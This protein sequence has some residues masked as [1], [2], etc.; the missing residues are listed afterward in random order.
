MPA[1]V[2]RTGGF[3]VSRPRPI[4]IATDLP[5]LHY[6]RVKPRTVRVVSV[7]T[8]YAW[9]PQCRVS[10]MSR[11]LQL[12]PSHRPVRCNPHHSHL[13]PASFDAVFQATGTTIVR[14]AGPGTADERD[15]RAPHRHPAP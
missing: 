14:T 9:L 13:V 3:T 11:E 12:S 10:F 4:G 1:R 8:E 5:F 7:A 15:L 2:F 6:R